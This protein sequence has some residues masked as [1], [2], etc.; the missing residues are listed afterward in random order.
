[1]ELGRRRS[2][3][4]VLHDDRCDLNMS[5]I[6]DRLSLDLNFSTSDGDVSPHQHTSWLSYPRIQWRL[7]RVQKRG[8]SS[9]RKLSRSIKKIERAVPRASCDDDPRPSVDVQSRGATRSWWRCW[10]SHSEFCVD[11]RV[12]QTV[13]C[14]GHVD[15]ATDLRKYPQRVMATSGGPG[16]SWSRSG[17]V[18]RPFLSSENLHNFGLSSIWE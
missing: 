2:N 7:I 17:Q 6:R 16:R 8:F 3:C 14:G 15:G 11:L 12:S 10:I 4:G 13:K 18:R 1:M 9:P 5:H